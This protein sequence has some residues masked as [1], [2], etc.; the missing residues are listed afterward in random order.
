M[1]HLHQTRA[2]HGCAFSYSM[3]TDMAQQIKA[4]HAKSALP[5][6]ENSAA[7]DDCS[8]DTQTIRNM[9]AKLTRLAC[10]HCDNEAQSIH[11]CYT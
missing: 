7:D 6:L 4:K 9:N 5:K 3:D 1:L 10:K 2:R 8:L 11:L